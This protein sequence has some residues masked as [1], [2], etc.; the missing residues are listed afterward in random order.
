MRRDGFRASLPI[1]VLAV[2]L[3]AT[4]GDQTEPTPTDP[5]GN[6]T[7]SI[8]RDGIE[9]RADVLVTEPDGA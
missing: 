4:C 3:G 8:V 9:Y 7:G 6:L 2:A 1:V 5:G